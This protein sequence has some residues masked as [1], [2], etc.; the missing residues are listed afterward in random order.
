MT[1]LATL[2]IPRAKKPGK[3]KMQRKVRH[4]TLEI[5]IAADTLETLTN[6]SDDYENV[7]HSAELL[8]KVIR[9]RADKV[10]AL[11]DMIDSL[12][13]AEEEAGQEAAR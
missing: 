9:Q 11:L 5:T 6:L 4:L 12:K 2:D 13:I 8:A 1:K 10:L 3:K 7:S